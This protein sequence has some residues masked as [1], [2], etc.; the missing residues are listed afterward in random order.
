MNLVLRPR[1]L[2]RVCRLAAV[3]VLVVFGGLAALLPSRAAQGQHIGLGDQLSFFAIGLLLVAGVLAL[4]RP[5]VR[6]SAEGVWVRN[7]L[8]ERFFPWAVVLQVRL[9][10]GAPWAQLDLHDDEQVPLL[11]VQ[12]NDG[13]LAVQAVAALNALRVG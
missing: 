2:R 12:A 4:S 6:A 11:G 1:R 7:V 5:R 3:V 8:G 13:E 9:P 10:D